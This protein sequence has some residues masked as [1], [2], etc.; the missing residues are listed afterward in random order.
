M[1][2]IVRLSY[3]WKENSKGQ[4]TFLTPSVGN[5]TCKYG[6]KCSNHHPL[7]STSMSKGLI[8]SKMKW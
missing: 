4:Q 3:P 1:N 8:H 6:T 2:A 7:Q 5:Q